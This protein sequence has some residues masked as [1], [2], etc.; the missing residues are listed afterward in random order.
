MIAHGVQVLGVL[1]LLRV[2][3]LYVFRRQSYRL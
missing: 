3:L 2:R 1:W